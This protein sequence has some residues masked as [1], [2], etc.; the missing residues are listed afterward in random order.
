MED[1][2]LPAD[3]ENFTDAKD[4]TS[5]HTRCEGS[6]CSEC[7]RWLSDT[8][9]D[10]VTADAYHTL[11]GPLLQ[12]SASLWWSLTPHSLSWDPFS[13]KVGL[14][15]TFC[16]TIATHDRN[17]M[18][19]KRCNDRDFMP[20]NRLKE[21][22]AMLYAVH[23]CMPISYAENM[24]L[25]AC[26]GGEKGCRAAGCWHDFQHIRICQFRHLALHGEGSAE[27]VRQSSHALDLRVLCPGS[28]FL[29]PVLSYLPAQ[30]FLGHAPCR[31]TCFPEAC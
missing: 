29:C 24:Y 4:R 22:G 3:N 10:S 28:V 9:E 8:Q 7:A 31:Y 2:L 13:H 11:T 21:M 20:C 30:L 26:R 14:L 23:H 6:P 25:T 17:Q 12:S 27:R 16:N 5:K 19:M 15:S 18:A 1:P